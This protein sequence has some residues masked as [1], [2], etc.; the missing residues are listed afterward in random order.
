MLGSSS[1]GYV[2]QLPLYVK[3][4][5][6]RRLQG[7]EDLSFRGLKGATNQYS[8]ALESVARALSI[9]IYIALQDFFMG[10]SLLVTI[11]LRAAQNTWEKCACLLIACF[12]CPS[13]NE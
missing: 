12:L 1:L 6:V 5:S 4:L 7:L 9:H 3:R 8:T 10:A 11:D 13:A 2:L